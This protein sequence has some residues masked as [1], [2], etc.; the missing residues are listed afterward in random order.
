MNRIEA[1]IAAGPRP[2]RRISDV[3]RDIIQPDAGPGELAERLTIGEI[4]SGLGQRAFGAGLFI[5]AFPACLPGPPGI[6]SIFGVPILLL[7][8]QMIM[9]DP[10]P[11]LPRFLSEKSVP[12]ATLVD[13]LRRI[14]PFLDR[15][16]NLS[17][18]R[19][20][21]L[22]GKRAER[23][24]GIA[25]LLFALVLC[26][27]MPFS[28]MVPSW[29]IALMGLGLIERDGLAILLGIVVAILG[30]A[31]SLFLAI[32]LGLAIANAL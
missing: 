5:F 11:W 29:G 28:N 16:E 17:R 26:L 18:P 14:Q 3:L 10:R 15:F 25:V 13:A 23:P 2:A 8:I 27:P 4:V 1:H 12:R 19:L 31:L 6:S 32:G 21:A 24:L 9:G 20:V 30:A 7:A 22:T